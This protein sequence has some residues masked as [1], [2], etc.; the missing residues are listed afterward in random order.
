V[1]VADARAILQASQ[2]IQAILQ[3]EL[4]LLSIA[5][6]QIVI[7]SIDLLP[8]PTPT[9]RVSIFLYCIHENPFLKN[10]PDTVA[11]VTA[12]PGTAD[13]SLPPLVIDLDYMICAWT[14]VTPDEHLLLGDI[15]RVLYDHSELGARDLGPSWQPDETLQISLTSPS[16]EDQA[17]IWTT[18]GFKR[19]KLSLYYKVRIV[20]IA[21]QRTFRERVAVEV[22]GP[23]VPFAPPE[24]ADV[25]G[26]VR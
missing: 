10:Q 26:F 12:I 6:S 1:I 14:A 7:E 2:G 22:H 18:F 17:R 21:S 16:I 24:P 8:T 5:P 11:P 13:G 15:A 3:S 9:P 20:P 19:F 4:T 25:P 23:V